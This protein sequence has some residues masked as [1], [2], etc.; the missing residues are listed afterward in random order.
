MKSKSIKKYKH[1]A[2]DSSSINKD[3]D[4]IYVST[5]GKKDDEFSEISPMREKIKGK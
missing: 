5:K 2:K 3:A 4:A 1:E